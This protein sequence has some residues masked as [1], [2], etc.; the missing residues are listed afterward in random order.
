MCPTISPAFETFVQMNVSVVI[1]HNGVTAA[2]FHVARDSTITATMAHLTLT[3]LC[4]TLMGATGWYM[5]VPAPR[6]RAQRVSC[7]TSTRHALAP[8]MCDRLSS[9]FQVCAHDSSQPNKARPTV[10]QPCTVTVAE[11]RGPAHGNSVRRPTVL[12]KTVQDGQCVGA[13]L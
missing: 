7:Q 2:H 9:E 13:A 12:A 10:S 8:Q 6:G 11:V 3:L 1:K 5:P 4:L